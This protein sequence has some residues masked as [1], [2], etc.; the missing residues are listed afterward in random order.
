M[1]SKLAIMFGG[2]VVGFMCGM[3]PMFIL[4]SMSIKDT[5]R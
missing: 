2:I 3:L 1:A 4:L 5:W